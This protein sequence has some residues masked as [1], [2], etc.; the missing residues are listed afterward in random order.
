MKQ[1]AK[2]A[3]K[4]AREGPAPAGLRL[5]FWS[6]PPEAHASREMVAAAYF[7]SPASLESYAIR[8]GGPPY[9]RIGRRSLYRKSDCLAWALSCGRTVENTAQLAVVTASGK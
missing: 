4:S 6:L 8:G 2:Q 1:S 3:R 5:E 7:L 9:T